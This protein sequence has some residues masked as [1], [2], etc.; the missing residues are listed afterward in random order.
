MR[1]IVLFIAALLFMAVPAMAASNVHINCS[2]DD[3][4]KVTISYVS[5]AN[6]IR[7]FGL[8]IT[9]DTNKIT[10]VVALDP[11]YRIYPGQ[12]VIVDGN[13]TDYNKPYALSDLGDANVTIE[14]GSLYTLDSNYSSDHNAGYLMQPGLSGDL[15]KFYVGGNCGYAISENAIRGGIVM[16]DPTEEPNV[17][18][19]S[20]RVGVLVVYKDFGDANNSYWTT[21]AVNGPNHLMADSNHGIGPRLGANIDAEADGQ[22]SANCL[23]DDTTG[24]PDDEDGITNLTVFGPVGN[25]TVTVSQAAGLLNAW[26]DFNNNGNFA[27]VNEQIFTNTAVAINANNLNFAVPAGAVKGVNLVSR[28]RVTSTSEPLAA[29][30]YYGPANSGE[31]EDYN[32]PF[33]QNPPMGPNPP[34]G[35]TN[36]YIYKDVNWVAGAGAVSHDVYFGTSNPPPFRINQTS[37]TYDTGIIEDYNKTYYWE[38]NEVCPGGKTPG[39]IWSFKTAIDCLDQNSTTVAHWNDWVAWGKPACWCYSRQCRG[40]INGKKTLGF[41]VQALDLAIFRSAVGQTDANLALIPNGIC[42]DLNQKKTLGFRVQALDL[43]IFRTYVGQVDANVPECPM[44]WD[45]ADGNDFRWWATP[46]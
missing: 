18:L 28:W 29:G 24:A 2:D 37:T 5:D 32:R 6:L 30:Y 16:E 15:L 4:N 45:G 44:N 10:K 43:A 8:D 40:D 38:V 25:V 46:P 9:V 13:I 19:C 42:A 31:V 27:D 35:A 34:D 3:I 1:K 20:G 21:M 11:N 26:V 12:I 17:T 7:A 41:Y 36:V 39:P 23:L 33:I 22:P 14:M